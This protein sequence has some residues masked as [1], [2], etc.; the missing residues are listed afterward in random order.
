MQIAPAPLAYI[1]AFGKV[2]NFKLPSSITQSNFC[3]RKQSAGMIFFRKPLLL[4]GWYAPRTQEPHFCPDAA[5]S[6]RTNFLRLPKERGVNV[7]SL[8]FRASR[9]DDEAKTASHLA[10]NYRSCANV[11]RRVSY[12]MTLATAHTLTHRGSRALR[13]SRP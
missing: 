1:L 2:R 11:S 12:L 13:V 8:W 6:A 10:H 5:P 4:D 3:R 7:C 9:S